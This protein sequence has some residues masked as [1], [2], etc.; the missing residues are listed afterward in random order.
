MV[1]I[2]REVEVI[3]AFLGEYDTNPAIVY[4]N[5]RYYTDKGEVVE[6]ANVF[7]LVADD[8]TKTLLIDEVQ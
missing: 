1:S 8:I 5:L 4:V 6:T 2:W 3:S 7:Y